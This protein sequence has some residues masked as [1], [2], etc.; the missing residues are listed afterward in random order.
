MSDKKEIL[1]YADW[2]GLN[3]PNYM[4]LLSAIPVK[5]KEVFSFEYDKSWLKSGFTHII[6]PDLQLYSGRY[7]PKE[8][9][10]NFGVFLDSSP[11][12]WGRVLM[13]RR[14]AALARKDKREINNL[15]E[16]DFLLGV[17]DIHRMG[18]LRFKLEKEGN[19]LNDNKLMASPPWVALRELEH[20]SRKFE[21]DNTTNDEFLK[22]VTMLIAPGSSLGGARPK[23]SVVDPS[24]HLWIAKFPSIKDKINIGAWEMVANKL[25][26]KAGINIPELDVK[27]FNN[28]HHTF[29]TKRFD[30]NVSGERIHFASAMTMLGYLDGDGYDSGVSYIEIAEFLMR[31]GAETN[32]DL[33][34]LWRRIVFSICIKNTDD[35]LRNHGFMLTGQGWRLSPAYDLNPNEFGDGLSL[36]ISEKDNAL[37]LDLALSVAELFRVK[38]SKATGIIDKVKCV[39]RE[40]RNVAT[41]HGISRTELALMANAFSNVEK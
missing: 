2:E 24:G 22:W 39:V 12:R 8:N 25:A 17:F 31:H 7:F 38:K 21:E 28:D 9:R 4:G 15:H 6:D 37:D 16:S 33:E 10:P 13:E 11:D 14:E 23:A 27:K 20:A 32:H 36:N 5:G 18:G 40:W 41:D 19:Y 1:V 29:L 26:K 34:E 35:H 3:E 30:R